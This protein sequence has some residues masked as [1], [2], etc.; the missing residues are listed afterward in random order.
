[1]N[2]CSIP[3]RFRMVGGG[4]VVPLV[5]APVIPC[6]YANVAANANAIAIAILRG[7]KL[8]DFTSCSFLLLPVVLSDSP[9]IQRRRLHRESFHCHRRISQPAGHLAPAAREDLFAPPARSQSESELE[10]RHW[11]DRPSRNCSESLHFRL[12]VYSCRLRHR[13]AVQVAE[14]V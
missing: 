13:P 3:P 6:P 2:F 9:A 5:A 7:L 12:S 11:P 4:C 8:L 1:F 10:P 14:T